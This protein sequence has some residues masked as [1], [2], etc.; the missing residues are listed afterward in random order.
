MGW[1]IALPNEGL[2]K[3]DDNVHGMIIGESAYVDYILNRLN[4]DKKV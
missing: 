4:K 2:I 1:T 3:D